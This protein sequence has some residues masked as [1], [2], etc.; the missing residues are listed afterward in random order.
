M[1]GT[2]AGAKWELELSL[3]DDEE[4]VLNFMLDVT[5]Y[6][7]PGGKGGGGSMSCPIHPPSAYHP[8]DD[9]F[10]DKVHILWG[11]VPVQTVQVE[12]E[13]C[14]G[15]WIQVA[16]FDASVLPPVAGFDSIAW[17]AFAEDISGGPPRVEL[18]WKQLRALDGGGTVLHSAHQN[19][20]SLAI[21]REWDEHQTVLGQPVPRPRSSQ[22]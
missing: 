21:H 9:F 2:F 19:D 17:Y 13:R 20:R 5:W 11:A 1:S 6:D 7:P 12:V 15:T 22:P 14:N 3:D 4:G 8:Q 18:R 16:P 10:R